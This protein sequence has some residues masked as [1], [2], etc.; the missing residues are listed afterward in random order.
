[1]M[2]PK[3]KK[4]QLSVRGFLI[5]ILMPCRWGKM[6]DGEMTE[7][8]VMKRNGSVSWER[9]HITNKVKEGAGDLAVSKSTDDGE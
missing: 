3:G 2:E 7:G 9:G 4:G 5:C 1:M 8:I 6:L